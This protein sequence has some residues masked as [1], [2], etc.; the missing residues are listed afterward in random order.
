MGKVGSV[1]INHALKEKGIDTLHGHWVLH[2]SPIGEFPTLK[3]QFKRKIENSP[4]VKVITPIR[5]PVGR[6]IS[7]FFQN[8]VFFK[9]YCEDYLKASAEELHEIFI[10]HYNIYYPD[11]WFELELMQLFNFDPFQSKFNYRKGYKIYRA[12]KHRILILRLEDA[13]RKLSES[14]YKLLKVRNIGMKNI[15][16]FADKKR[17]TGEKYKKFLTL[18]LPEEFLNKNYNLK[19]AQHF[20]T[21]KEREVFKQGWLNE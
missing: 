12:D 7:A 11:Q 16:H 3:P 1:S 8:L 19:Y 4:Q 5:E 6:N 21:K 9:G 10:K 18:P 2:D 13:D 14:I 15:N 17:G 20:Y